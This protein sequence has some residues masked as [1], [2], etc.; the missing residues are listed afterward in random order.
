MPPP[1]ANAVG[2]PGMPGLPRVA[3]RGMRLLREVAVLDRLLRSCVRDLRRLLTV[4]IVRVAEAPHPIR[5][6]RNLP[7]RPTG[8]NPRRGL[9]TESA[10]AGNDDRQAEKQGGCAPAAR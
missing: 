3:I 8:H 2:T 5:R 4:G 9:V 7:I 6:P 1:R 10:R